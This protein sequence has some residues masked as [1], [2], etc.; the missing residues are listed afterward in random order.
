M[1]LLGNYLEGERRRVLV[2][3]CESLEIETVQIGR[4]AGGAQDPLDAI[5]R[6]DIV[7]G[8]GRAIVEAMAC[9]ARCVRLRLVRL[10]GLGHAGVVR[11]GS[12]RAGS[13]GSARTASSASTRSAVT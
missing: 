10:R 7:V 12:S 11:A 4:H 1:L 6:A 13:T 2:E 3:A 9:G 5:G 8:K